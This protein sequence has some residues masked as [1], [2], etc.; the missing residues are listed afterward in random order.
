MKLVQSRGS[1]A[2][3]PSLTSHSEVDMEETASKEKLLNSSEVLSSSP[4]FPD[5]PQ[6]D[7]KLRKSYKKSLQK[8]QTETVSKSALEMSSS[9]KDEKGHNVAS[10]L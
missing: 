6:N 10:V 3:Q 9:I 4:L 7:K 2:E 8:I 1:A 5:P